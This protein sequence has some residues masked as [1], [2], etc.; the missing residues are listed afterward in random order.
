MQVI[1]AEQA[2]AL[3]QPGDNILVS[4]SG[5]GHAVPERILEAVEAR[6]LQSGQ[7]RDLCLIHVVG[8][9]DR[10]T[11]GAAR[12]AHPGMLR[13]SITSALIDSP[14]LIDL[15]LRDAFESY[16]LPQGVLSQ[17][18]RDMAAG[19][20]GL[21]TRTGL[22]T[23]VDPRHGGGR[24]SASAR[25]DLVELME[26]DGE[27][28]LR[29]KPFPLDV[30]FLRGTTADE[31][32]NVTMEHEAVPCEMISCAQAARRQ[33]AAVVVQVKRLARRGT[34]PPR[35]VK[36]PGILVD[37]IVV[38]P[39]QRQTYHTD[40]NPSYAGELRVP[41]EGFRRLEFDHRKIIARR[42][43]MELVPGAICNLGA[44]ISTGISAIAAEEGILDLIVLTNE[45][46]FI[47]GAPL[48]GPDSGAAQNYDAM[49]DQP[50]QFDFYDGGGLDVAFLSAAEVDPA[51]N[52]N[53]SRFASKIV[54]IGGFIN[55][56][57]NARKVVFSG[58][59]S[60]GGLQVACG[61]GALQIIS[62]GRHSKFVSRI[63]QVC[64]N[65]QLAETEGRIALFVTERG[66]F[67]S[68]GGRLE[69]IEIAPGINLERDILDRMAFRPE[70]SSDL[71]LMDQRL[72]EPGPMGLRAD[73]DRIARHGR[74]PRRTV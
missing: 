55:I 67:R 42:A 32:G 24:Q 35:L 1:T 16:T 10:V 48:T 6:F 59:F 17:I 52:V 11:K 40:H 22:H 70:V 8:L 50:Y 69:L 12:F 41:T 5:G 46:G 37:Y 27:E 54:G 13:R 62:E 36:I 28:W 61:N 21:I 53:I 72:F 7:P 49:V 33:G 47:G 34:L 26:I 19:R 66:V 18:M 63:E 2:A 25:E 68:R 9:G 4:G 38:D 73:L 39:A 3:V 15:A 14:P 57:Q 65:A 60:A 29:F 31:D 43:A 45:Q 44:G 23:F 58:T 20:P 71:K 64:Y 56:S 51:G 74:Y 30:V